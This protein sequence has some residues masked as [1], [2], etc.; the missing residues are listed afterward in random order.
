MEERENV[1]GDGKRG[2]FRG[3]GKWGSKAVVDSG[4]GTE[5]AF[6]VNRR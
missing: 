3:K 2:G 6:G 4:F 1:G 5:T